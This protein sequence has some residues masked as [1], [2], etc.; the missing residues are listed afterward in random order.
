MSIPEVVQFGDGHFRH[1]L[2]GLG[3]YIANY[4]KQLV[5]GC[6]IQNKDHLVALIKQYLEIEHGKVHVKEILDDIDHCY[7][8]T[9]HR[10]SPISTRT[11]ILVMD[12]QQFK[13]VDL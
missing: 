1:V 6:V 2:Y 11:W 8:S 12:R 10:T 3:P 13:V 7:R 9:F 5:L 4:P